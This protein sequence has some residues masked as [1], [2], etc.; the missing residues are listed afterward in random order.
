MSLHHLNCQSLRFI[1]PLYRLKGW[2]CEYFWTAL[3]FGFFGRMQCFLLTMAT[4]TGF[5]SDGVV[6]QLWTTLGFLRPTWL[7]SMQISSTVTVQPTH[8]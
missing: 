6:V 5:W 3:P 1:F 4:F 8:R 7:F 2:G